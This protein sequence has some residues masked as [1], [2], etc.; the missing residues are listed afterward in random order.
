MHL[1]V[2]QGRHCQFPSYHRP[3]VRAAALHV[4]RSVALDAALS[5]RWPAGVSGPAGFQR[6]GRG[7]YSRGGRGAATPVHDAENPGLV[8]VPEPLGRARGHVFGRL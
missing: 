5:S 6:W 4:W 8:V 1:Y 7:V 3:Y 2:Q